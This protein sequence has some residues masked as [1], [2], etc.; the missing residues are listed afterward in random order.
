M[1]KARLSGQSWVQAYHSILSQ[2]PLYISAKKD[3]G[4]GMIKGEHT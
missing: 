2:S 1:E 4:V 3:A